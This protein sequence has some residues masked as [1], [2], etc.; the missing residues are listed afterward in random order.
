MVTDD[1]AFIAAFSQHPTDTLRQ[2]IMVSCWLTH[3]VLDLY[4]INSNTD[5]WF[6]SLHGDPVIGKLTYFP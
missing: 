3:P 4:D 5:T 2:T 6:V 1:T